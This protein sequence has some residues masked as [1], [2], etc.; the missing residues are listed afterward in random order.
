VEH[1]GWSAFQFSVDLS[2]KS[3]SQHGKL[4]FWGRAGANLSACFLAKAEAKA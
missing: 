1:A 3:P 2:K 4:Y